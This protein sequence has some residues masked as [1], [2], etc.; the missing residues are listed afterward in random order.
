MLEKGCPVPRHVSRIIHIVRALLFLL[1]FSILEG[2]W[3]FILHHNLKRWR[4]D[5]APKNMAIYQN[6]RPTLSIQFLKTKTEIMYEAHFLT[7][8]HKV[9]KCNFEYF[10]SRWKHS[11]PK[12]MSSSMRCCHLMSGIV[13]LHVCRLDKL[14]KLQLSKIVQTVPWNIPQLYFGK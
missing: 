12:W 6:W 11:H 14:N 9:L 1:R 2:L 10:Q 8:F 7:I 3:I 4:R 5:Y 13:L